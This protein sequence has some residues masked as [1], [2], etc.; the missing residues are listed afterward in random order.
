MSHAWEPGKKDFWESLRIKKSN[1]FRKE[2]RNDC[3][4]TFMKKETFVFI[5]VNLCYNLE[6]SQLLESY[7]I[8]YKNIIIS[9]PF[10]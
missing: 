2:K 5:L 1:I 6:V 9:I 10:D 3:I 4:N 7:K 8:Q